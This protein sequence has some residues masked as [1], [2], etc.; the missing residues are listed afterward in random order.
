MLIAELF[1]DHDR[2]GGD[3]TEDF[4]TEIGGLAGKNDAGRSNVRER[5]QR[6]FGTMLVAGSERIDRVDFGLKGGT[7][8]TFRI[9]RDV[10][11]SRDKRPCNDSVA[12]ML[13]PSDTTT[14]M[15]GGVH[16]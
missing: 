5:P 6:S 8:T 4:C 3:V 13:P 10:R 11:F 1:A 2:E 9:N 15:S 16:V 7:A 12:D 14:E